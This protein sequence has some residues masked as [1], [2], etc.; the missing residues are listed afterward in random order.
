MK[1]VVVT[2]ATRGLGFAICE[3]LLREGYRIVAVARNSNES[4]SALL[5]QFPEQLFFHAF[6]FTNL[7]GIHQL[8][9]EI[10]EKY[11]RVYGLVNNAAIGSDGVLAT[12]HDNDIGH[13][14]SVNVQAPII[15][16]KYLIRPMLMNQ[17]GRV[18][19]VSS[20]IAETGYS[21]LSVYGASKAA[22]VGFT[23][24]LAR[25]V[26]KAKITVNAIAPGFMRTQM[27]GELDDEKLVSIA[28]RSALKSLIS[29]DDVAQGV[30]YL[31][32]SG[33]SSVTGTTLT[34]DAGSTA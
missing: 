31:L 29:C 14:L 10:A 2:G 27:T 16:T 33:A 5:E 13:L 25:E 20:I 3:K 4:F 28:R 8:A 21:G 22:L 12:M 24:S 32:S 26:G 17:Q 6:D 23:K 1:V 34:I 30:S 19:N 9:K 18:I 11:G 15:L 7:D